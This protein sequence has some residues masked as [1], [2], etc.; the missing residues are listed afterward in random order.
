MNQRL[1]VCLVALLAA[2]ALNLIADESVPVLP[3]VAYPE[4]YRSW[5]HISSAVLPPKEGAATVQPSKEKAPA[6]HGLIHHV[7]AN[8]AAL[9]GYRTG[10][11]PEGAVLIADWFVLEPRGPELIQG[12]RKSV[13]VMIRDAR[14]SATGGWGFEDFQGDSHTIRNIGPKAIT[15]CFECHRRAAQHEF[16]FTTLKENAPVP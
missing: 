8:E 2:L 7:Y 14:Y 11:F 4:G 10:H 16:V 5:R 13:N 3:A 12:P 9:E 1:P 15:A 6:P